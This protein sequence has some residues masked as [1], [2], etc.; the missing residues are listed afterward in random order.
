MCHN[1][2]WTKSKHILER[3]WVIYGTTSNLPNFKKWEFIKLNFTETKKNKAKFASLTT[4]PPSTLFLLISSFNIILCSPIQT[5]VS[6]NMSIIVNHLHCV[7][8]YCDSVF[9]PN[10]DVLCHINS[11]FESKMT[12]AVSFHFSLFP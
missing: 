6:R 12:T 1:S 11:I 5:F 8:G 3:V 4:R 7:T 9:W 2:K 10:L